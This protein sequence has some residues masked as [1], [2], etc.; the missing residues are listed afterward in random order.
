[1]TQAYE[2]I[3]EMTLTVQE[4]E[5]LGFSNHLRTFIPQAREDDE[6]LEVLEMTAGLSAMPELIS[7]SS[8][9][10]FGVY[11][12]IWSRSRGEGLWSD[13]FARGATA[14]ASL[15]IEDSRN[16]LNMLLSATLEEMEK[17]A[18]YPNLTVTYVR[19]S[20]E[21]SLHILNNQEMMNRENLLAYNHGL[22]WVAGYIK[23]LED[24]DPCG[25]SWMSAV[26]IDRADR[27]TV[28]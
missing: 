2:M 28:E 1:M 20:L 7:H 10:A 18:R 6:S 27:A 26:L 13:A 15:L 5:G 19:R 17:Y 16:L 23:G 12:G 21:V 4:L 22:W 11:Q 3:R 8:P 25:P 14:L 9:E 24:A